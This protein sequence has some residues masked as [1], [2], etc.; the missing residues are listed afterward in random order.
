MNTKS[1]SQLGGRKAQNLCW[2]SSS[3]LERLHL[4]YEFRVWF[5][6]LLWEQLWLVEKWPNYFLCDQFYFFYLHY[7]VFD[8]YYKE[9]FI[10]RKKKDGYFGW[11]TNWY[12]VGMEIVLYF[13]RMLCETNKVHSHD[14]H[15][16]LLLVFQSVTL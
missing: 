11:E 16:E 5:A 8:P 15:Y 12:L 9:Y 7:K 14:F 10:L 6:T 13:E 3:K 2:G 1:T 4:F